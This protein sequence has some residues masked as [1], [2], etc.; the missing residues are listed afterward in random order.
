M[1]RRDKLAAYLTAR[2]EA[3][4]YATLIGPLRRRPETALRLR[5][6]GGFETVELD[7]DGKVIE[8]VRCTC[9]P[10]ISFNCPLHRGGVT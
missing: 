2:F 5:A 4:M 1:I 9:G 8:P 3:E 10:I 7:A 6:S